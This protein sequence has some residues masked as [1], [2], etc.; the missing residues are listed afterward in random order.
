MAER[1]RTIGLQAG[2]RFVYTDAVSAPETASTFC[3]DCHSLIIERIGRR[4]QIHAL[5]PNGACACCGTDL[6]IVV[7]GNEG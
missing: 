4:V 1:G 5:H 3:P 7:A 6:G 2:L